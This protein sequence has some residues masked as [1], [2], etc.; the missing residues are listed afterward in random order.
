[1]PGTFT[2]KHLANGQLAVAEGDLYLVPAATTAII[3]TVTLV[4]IDS[5]T[6]TMN[7]YIKTAAG[8]SRRIIPKD[9]ALQAGF[10]LET[11]EEYTLG[12]AD[13][14]RG[15]GSAAAII[16]FTVNGVEET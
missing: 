15:D 16:D 8:T 12:A 1:M 13:A 10:S 11:D 4:N 3:K 14:V 5:V 7:L 6:R 9:T 2:I